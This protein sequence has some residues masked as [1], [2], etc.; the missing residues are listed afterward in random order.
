MNRVVLIGWIIELVGVVLWFYGY[1]VTGHPPLI[2][3]RGLTPH[4]IAEWMPNIEAE[5]GMALILV[6]MIPMYWPDR[7]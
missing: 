1:F 7:R 5:I 6:G 4:W 3:W 2:D